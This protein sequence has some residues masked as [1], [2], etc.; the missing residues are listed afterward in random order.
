MFIVILCLRQGNVESI[1]C[2]RFLKCILLLFEPQVCEQYT[3][4]FIIRNSLFV[5]RALSPIG[6]YF[7]TLANSFSSDL[8]FN[9]N[10]FGMVRSYI[11]N[12]C[13]KQFHNVCTPSFLCLTETIL[14]RDKLFNFDPLHKPA[15]NIFFYKFAVL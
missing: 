14:L 7:Y 10:S 13:C 8:V 4:N 6:R 5:C 12:F 15:L 3:A 1:L 9:L 11:Y 2:C